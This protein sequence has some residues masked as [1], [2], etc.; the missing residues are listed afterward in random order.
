MTALGPLQEALRLVV[1]VE[2]LIGR[3]R[4]AV[5]EGICH[6]A[7]LELAA[8][9]GVLWQA[10]LAKRDARFVVGQCQAGRVVEGKGAEVR[11]GVEAAWLLGEQP[12]QQATRPVTIGPGEEF[13]RFHDRIVKCLSAGA[14]YQL[15]LLPGLS[16][17]SYRP[18]RGR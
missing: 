14:R 2:Q 12:R 7:R 16:K 10:A 18:R 8:S 6:T 3:Q 17:G 1:P 15:L 11:V 5:L 4:R 9:P 13:G